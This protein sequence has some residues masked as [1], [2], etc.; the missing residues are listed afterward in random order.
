LEL[1]ARFTRTEPRQSNSPQQIP[2]PET[3]GL[4]RK[5]PSK[6]PDPRA[7]AKSCA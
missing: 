7:G 6:N 5:P 4:L 1:A 3:R 2:M